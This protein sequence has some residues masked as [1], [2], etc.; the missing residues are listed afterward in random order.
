MLSSVQRNQLALLVVI[1]LVW[2]LFVGYQ[3]IMGKGQGELCRQV[4]PYEGR[5]GACWCPRAVLR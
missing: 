4:D 5:L 3:T 1:L 2:S